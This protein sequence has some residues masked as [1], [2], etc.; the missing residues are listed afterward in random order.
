VRF[1][2][3][4]ADGA[5]E[6]ALPQRGLVS[7]LS[8][9]RSVDRI[10]TAQPSFPAGVKIGFRSRYLAE[11]A[12]VRCGSIASDLNRANHFRSCPIG[13]PSQAH[14]ASLK[15]ANMR[16]RLDG[17]SPTN[18]FTL[19]L[20]R[21]C[22]MF[23]RRTRCSKC[24]RLYGNSQDGPSPRQMSMPPARRTMDCSVVSSPAA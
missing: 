6:L 23:W 12:R 10:L 4:R 16:H 3:A 8:A 20:R 15:R 14:A 24:L 9:I 19:R 7:R 22:L 2:F 1:G 21:C 17:K 5:P 13:R 18:C 11:E